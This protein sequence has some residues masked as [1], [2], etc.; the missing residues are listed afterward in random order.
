MRKE[1]FLE[2]RH[3]DRIEFKAF[4]RV[5]GHQLQGI[6]ALASLVLTGLQ[7][8]MCKKSCQQRQ[9]GLRV[10]CGWI[11][12]ESHRRIHQL[13]QVI[14]PLFAVTLGG[15][16]RQELTALVDLFNQLGQ[17]EAKAIGLQGIH[18]PDESGQT[19]ASSLG[20]LIERATSR[21]RR[22]L[23][24]LDRSGT[25][26]AG[27][28]IDHPQKCAVIGRV[29]D[30]AQ[31]GQR[32]LD[33][34]P[35]KK[36]QAAVDPVRHARREQGVLE[37]SGL[38]V[39]SVE[40]RNIRPHPTIA[41]KTAHLFDDPLGLV[42]IAQC[43]PDPDRFTD[44]SLCPELLAQSI[45]IALNQLIGAIQ[46][47]PKRTIV[48]FK[49]NQVRGLKIALERSHVADIRSAKCIDRLV[50]ITDR[51][52]RRTRA[53]QQSNPAV[54]QRIGVLKLIDQQVPKPRLIVV[55]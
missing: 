43:L 21:A 49:T 50:V 24:L 44:P 17:F 5:D 46:N 42:L 13:A 22:V 53:C 1:A 3:E 37:H 16:V 31:I 30:Q 10:L 38:S 25:D 23:Q 15:V 20:R 40:Q 36:T 45:G 32:M 19:A 4:R 41:N 12:Q 39:R 52:Y 11:P 55:A 35:L 14:D 7:R 27:R 2:A 33:F 28:K 18:Q 48:L 8:C 47:M 6:R 51:E 9:R 34:S 29:F 26:P 54:L